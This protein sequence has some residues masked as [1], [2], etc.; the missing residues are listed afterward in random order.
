MGA[1]KLFIACNKLF[2]ELL[3]PMCFNKAVLLEPSVVWEKL[4]RY[5]PS[6]SE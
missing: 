4:A 1:K 2:S 6:D 3:E 5:P